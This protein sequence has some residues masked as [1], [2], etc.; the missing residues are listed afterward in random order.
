MGIKKSPEPVA[1][2]LQRCA[3]AT[4]AMLHMYTA[5]CCR[6]P[7]LVAGFRQSPEP[8]ARHVRESVFI[9]I[10]AHMHVRAFWT[11]IAC[12]AKCRHCL[13]WKADAEERQEQRLSSREWA[14]QDHALFHSSRSVRQ[15][16]DPLTTMV[17]RGIDHLGEDAAVP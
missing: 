4:R 7:E 1:G 13:V 15:P 12:L 6:C 10:Y 9:C 3:H 16:S 5:I 17:L 11:C 8:V 2:P 14:A